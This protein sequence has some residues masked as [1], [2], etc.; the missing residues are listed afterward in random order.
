MTTAFI[1]VSPS[2][3][4][5]LRLP[6]SALLANKAQ[7]LWTKATGRRI[8]GQG[9]IGADH[10]SVR[11]GFA[12]LVGD[13]FH[14]Y[15][16]P[17]AWVERRQIPAVLHERV[18]KHHARIVDLGCG[19]GT[20]TQILCHF[21]DP[22]W[23]ILGYDLTPHL[24]DAARTRAARGELKNRGGVAIHP[25]FHCQSIAD[26]LMVFSVPHDPASPLVPVP[27]HSIDL[28]LSGGVVGLYL[29][30]PQVEALL[31]ELSRIIK[32]NGYIALDAGPAIPVDQLT[33]L[34][35]AAGFRYEAKAKSFVIEPRPKLIFQKPA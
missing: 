4:R 26:S 24:V 23:T 32:P 25:E 7:E 29:Q 27:G 20:S 8:K 1:S 13:D 11:D 31:V 19:P 30:P 2:D 21:A 33:A 10:T 34:A 14:E 35:T 5:S 22:T 6:W 28:A 18:P 17:Q 16:L 15:N 12:S 9:M 3:L